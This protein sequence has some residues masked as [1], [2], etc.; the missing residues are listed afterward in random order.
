MN[1][2]KSIFTSK[3]F[4]VNVGLVVAA[5]VQQYT[6]VEIASSEVELLVAGVLNIALRFATTKPAK[7]TG[8]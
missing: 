1:D 8:G 3:T 6:D 2:T 7:L 4:W 5:L